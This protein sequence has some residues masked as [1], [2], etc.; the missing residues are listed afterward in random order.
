MTDWEARYQANDLPWEKG[1]PSPGL[2]DFL[3]EHPLTGSVLVPGCGFGHDVRAISTAENDVLG[4]DL[5]P[6]AIR[7]AQAFP[8]RHGERY[9]SGDLFAL[10]E[11]FTGAF[12]WVFEH[13][14]FCAINPGLR[15]AYVESVARALKPGGHLLGVFF[16]NPEMEPGELGPP[17]GVGAEELT[18]Y[19]AGQFSVVRRWRPVRTYR[20]R[21]SREEMRLLVRR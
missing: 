1:E 12:D 7:A 13:T 2:V 14:C 10:P 20:G 8:A 15:T 18:A 3:T 6:S 21:E 16:L 5:A 11:E 19:L 17:F 4:L 9:V